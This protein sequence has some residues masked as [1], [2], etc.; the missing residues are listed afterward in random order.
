MNEKDALS[1]FSALSNPSRLNV[2]R[3]LVKASPDG[4]PAG[5]IAEALSASPSQTSFHLSALS[6]SGLIASQRQA[7]H[8]IYRVNF[9]AFRGLV[10]FLLEDC[11]KGAVRPGD[12]C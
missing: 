7:R 11:C 3:L 8:M 10:G 9:D 4:M 12:C 6:E 5:E 2:V 1:A